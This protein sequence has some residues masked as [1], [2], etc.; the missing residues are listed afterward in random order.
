[1]DVLCSIKAWKF[2]LALLMERGI[3][4]IIGFPD[5]E[6]HIPYTVVPILMGE[7]YRHRVVTRDTVWQVGRPTKKENFFDECAKKRNNYW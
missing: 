3:Q 1:M 2:S 7:F 6:D 5:D 4:T